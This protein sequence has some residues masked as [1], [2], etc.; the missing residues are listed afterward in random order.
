MHAFLLR[1]NY[2]AYYFEQGIKSPDMYDYL[3]NYDQMTQCMNKSLLFRHFNEANRIQF[4]P[5]YKFEIG[6]NEYETELKRVPSFTDRIIY[7]NKRLGHIINFQYNCVPE[8]CTSDHKPV[9]GLFEVTIRHGRD[10]IPLNLGLFNR[11]VIFN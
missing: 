1:A 7:R 3:L 6:S 8:F 5:T 2:Y 11:E 4:A 10:D 9:F